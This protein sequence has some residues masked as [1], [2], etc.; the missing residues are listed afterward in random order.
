M[1]RRNVL[2]RAALAGAALATNPARYVL[3]PGTAYES[4]CFC[5]NPGCSC[6][7]TCCEGFTQF[8]CT[9]NGGY[10]FCP[11]GSVL[12]GWW[13]ADHSTYCNGARYYLDCNAE[14]TC[15]NGCGNGWQFCD[16]GCDHL[17]CECALGSC[18][19]WVTGCFQFRYGQC[20]QDISCL[21]RIKCRVVSCVPP[22]EID[23]TCTRTSATDNFTAEMNT[24]CNTSVPVPP[25]PAPVTSL[26]VTGV[27]DHSVSLSW[28]NPASP[29]FAGVVIRR[30]AGASPPRS[31]ATGTL[32]AKV[33]APGDTYTDT[34]LFEDTTYSYALFAHT[35]GG[36]SRA[37]TVTALTDEEEPMYLVKVHAGHPGQAGWYVITSD[38]QKIPVATPGDIAR[39]QHLI[40]AARH[41]TLSG[42]QIELLPNA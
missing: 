35:A 2:A 31:A 30:E 22:W 32:V 20:N 3:R 36:D 16:P 33:A 14:C 7:S 8:C 37:T 11:E 1:S 25:P 15:E 21:G 12:G 26:E 28:K 42:A 39:W 38:G 17:N 18:D 9:L 29:G 23:P 24:P 40:P 34:G 10:N 13:K 6:G 41:G 27:T 19:N 4:L 5:G